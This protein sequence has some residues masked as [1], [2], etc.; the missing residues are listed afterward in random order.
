MPQRPSPS[1]AASTAA[2]V[3]MQPP[4]TPS[5]N[6][7]YHPSLDLAG[8][9]LHRSLTPAPQCPVPDPGWEPGAGALVLHLLWGSPSPSP[10]LHK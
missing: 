8:S 5:P 1:R 3:N 10:T 9:P 2:R 6:S 4:T 7:A